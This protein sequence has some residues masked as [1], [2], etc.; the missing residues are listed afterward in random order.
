MY[1]MNNKMVTKKKNLLICYDFQYVDVAKE[2]YSL[3]CCVENQRGHLCC[4]NWYVSIH[5]LLCRF[6]KS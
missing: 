5:L 3:W 2:N 4:R 1:I 6:F